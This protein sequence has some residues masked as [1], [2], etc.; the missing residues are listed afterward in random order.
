MA[1]SAD[2]R[3]LKVIGERLSSPYESAASPRSDLELGPIESRVALR[4]G[5]GNCAIG[6]GIGT[7]NRSDARVLRYVLPSRAI[8]APV[9]AAASSE[10]R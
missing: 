9:I 8:L 4:V 5:R 3:G 1:A 10:H 7:D 6:V 2:P